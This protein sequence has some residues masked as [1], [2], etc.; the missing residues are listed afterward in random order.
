MFWTVLENQKTAGGAYALL[1]NHYT[2][3]NEAYSR[4]YT[5]CAAAAVSNIP[6]HAAHLIRSDGNVCEAR[7]WDRTAN[8]EE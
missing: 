7:V 1:Y 8:T 4:F 2:D 3:E 6:Y 5:I